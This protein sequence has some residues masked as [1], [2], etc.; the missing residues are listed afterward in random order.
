MYINVKEREGD[1]INNEEYKNYKAISNTSV[2][3]ISNHSS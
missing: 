1:S 3:S 2:K